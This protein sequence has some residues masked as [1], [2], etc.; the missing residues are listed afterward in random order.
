MP[1]IHMLIKPASSLCN[2]RCK[3]CFYSDVSEHRE[4]KS[5]GLMDI[6][7]LEKITEKALS[8][9]EGECSFSFQG[10]EPA[11][12]GLDFYKKL[13]EFQKKYNKKKLKIN[14]AIQ[15]NGYCIDH[16]W[17]EFFAKNN[18][19]VG[20]SVDGS[21]EMHDYM[22][23]DAQGKGTYSRIMKTSAI[24]D[25]YNVQYNILCVVNNFVARRPT[26]VYNDLKKF[27]YLQFIPCLD[28]FDGEKRDFSLDTER[29]AEFLKVT[30]DCYYKDFVS[31]NYVSIRN[32][33]NYVMMLCGRIPEA[34]G[35]LGFC[36]CYFV[37]EGDGSV[38]PCDFYVVDKYK[39]GNIAQSSFSEL[40][41]SPN[42]LLFTEQSK[43]VS[44][45]CRECKW[46]NICRGGCRR[47][48]E[49]FVDE[50]PGLNIYCNAYKQFF[51]YAYERMCHLASIARGGGNYGA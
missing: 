22:R 3:Y 19:L 41:A 28:G 34:C 2:M 32:F 51:E 46:I 45:E 17:A 39:L 9:A 42:A 5:Y 29:Y 50:K 24:F 21:K 15:T 23:V 47:N 27:K 4:I 35:M 48:R 43:Y 30:F 20:L 26:K 36:S 8:E 44:E 25:K 14:N 10:G 33:D 6:A 1:P 38:F 40:R 11:L 16:E 49:P 31:G 12:A 7:L 18:Y 13:S 37:I